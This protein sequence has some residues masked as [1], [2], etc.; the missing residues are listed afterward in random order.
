MRIPGPTYLVLAATCWVLAPPGQAE[1]QF[2]DV[3][4]DAVE[5]EAERQVADK[6]R[7]EVANLFRCVW[8][9]LECIRGAEEEDE[10][11]AL[12]DEEGNLLT[13]EEGRPISDPAEARAIMSAPGA[14]TVV[15]TI[16]MIVDG[17][18]RVFDV[19]QGPA[20]RGF[21]TGYSE[22]PRGES[23][24][25]GG[26][27]QGWDRESDAKIRISVGV[28]RETLEHMC[29]PF[30]NQVEFSSADPRAFGKRLRP[31]G[32]PS[33]TCPPPPGGGMGGLPIQLNLTDA[34]L[35]EATGA[36]HVTGTFA[37]PLGRGNDVLEI[38]EGRFEATLLPFDE[39]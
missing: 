38:S 14:G 20:D 8:N 4:K 2:P 9:D 12:T 24:V 28:W 21:A 6:A 18:M 1:A 29:D 7:R 30:A 11:L 27:L 31:D 39:L 10:E 17:E 35:D 33:E 37:G 16:E 13:D 34:T 23:L 15:G 22:Q 36:L 19:R 5:D 26:G 32:H 3:V 25:L